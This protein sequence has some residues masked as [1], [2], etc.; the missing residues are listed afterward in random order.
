[1][2]LSPERLLPWLAEAAFLRRDYARTRQTL[3]RLD[4]GALPGVLRQTVN[5]WTR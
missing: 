4:E 2:P 1:M 3:A 5:Y